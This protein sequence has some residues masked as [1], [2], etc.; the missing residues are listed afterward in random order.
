VTVRKLGSS[1][2]GISCPTSDRKLASPIDRTPGLSQLELAA[3][4]LGSVF[5]R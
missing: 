2:V 5:T 1:D 3:P 4:E